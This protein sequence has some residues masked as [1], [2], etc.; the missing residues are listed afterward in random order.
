MHIVATM[1][2][3]LLHKSKWPLSATTN[4]QLYLLLAVELLLLLFKFLDA[5]GQIVFVVRTQVLTG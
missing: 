2:H 4:L 1:L 5:L 3:L